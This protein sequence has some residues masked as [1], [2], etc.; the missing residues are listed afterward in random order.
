MAS[1]PPVTRRRVASD[2]APKEGTVTPAQAVA[3]IPVPGAPAPAAP[4]PTPAPAVTPPKP[5][6]PAK[7]ARPRGRRLKGVDLSDLDLG[8]GLDDDGDPLPAEPAPLS[9][10]ERFAQGGDFDMAALMADSQA[11]SA[12]PEPGTRVQGTVLRVSSDTVYIDMGSRA[13][14]WIA[15]RDA[16]QASVGDVVE[17]FVVAA[18]D[19]GV[20]LSLKLTGEA[21]AMHLEE[22]FEGR[23]PV[24]GHVDAHHGGGYTVKVG[25]VRAF[26]PIS[27]MSR[28]PLADPA[29]VVGQTLTFLV[30]EL[31]DKVVLSRRDLEEQEIEGSLDARR[32]S[33]SEGDE[34]TAIIT[35]VQPWGAFLDVDG[36]DL[37]MPKHE[38]TWD[39]IDDLSTRFDR[40]QT[41]QVRI[42]RIDPDN[43]RITVSARDPS[44][45]PWTTVSTRFPSG[46]VAKGTVVT[47]TDFGVFVELAP[48]LQGLVHRSRLAAKVPAPGDALE[49]RILSI[50]SDRRRLELAPSDFD[51][52]MQAAN[53][54]GVSVSGEVVEV[55]DRGV[56]VRLADGRRAWLPAREVEL[57]AGTVLAQRFRAGHVIEARIASEDD[58]GDRV[59]LTQRSQDSDDWRGAMK[60]AGK[61][62]VGAMGTLG[63]LL[64]KWSSN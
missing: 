9:E 43:G 31:G 64:G 33:L 11:L 36:V 62:E 23:I 17:A 19:L 34:V 57:D 41:L 18:D 55:T 61:T 45:D 25:P 21:A 8:D 50:D 35:S 39:A 13:E 14:G 63:D 3:A 54:A 37:R 24:E 2:A 42:T 7:P 27:Q 38:A 30:R 53:T 59:T 22:A 51:P 12:L 47:Q 5:V 46:S 44:L 60:Q 10:L 58:R 56:T 20:E 28:L 16:A 4:P 49:V 1:K 6:Q 32:A 15:R 48:G 29:S 40:G 52:S 26:C